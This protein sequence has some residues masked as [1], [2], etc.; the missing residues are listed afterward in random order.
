[1]KKEYT[2]NTKSLLNNST[3]NNTIIKEFAFNTPKFNPFEDLANIIAANIKKEN[4]YLTGFDS[5]EPKTPKIKHTIKY[6]LSEPKYI[7]KDNAYD[8]L[9]IND[10]LNF[11]FDK[12]DNY[13]Y[14]LTDGTPIKIYDDEIQIGLNLFSKKNKKGIFDFLFN[15][16]KNDSIKIIIIKK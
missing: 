16:K 12:E 1:M 15:H 9:D 5:F 6:T 8:F 10:A 3:T 13:D 4:P 11:L 2:F 7:L 14:K